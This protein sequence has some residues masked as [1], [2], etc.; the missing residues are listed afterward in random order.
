MRA[1]VTLAFAALILGCSKP[2]PYEPHDYL[3]IHIAYRVPD[4]VLLTDVTMMHEPLLNIRNNSFDISDSECM[5]KLKLFSDTEMQ[6]VIAAWNMSDQSKKPAIGI[7][8]QCARTNGHDK[9]C[10]RKR[11]QSAA[12]I[13][14]EELGVQFLKSTQTSCFGGIPFG[15]PRT[16][17][18]Q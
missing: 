10:E 18:K 4:R 6:K 5:E 14:N 11:L 8:L 3:Q 15:Q 1:I 7:T 12:S 16:F 13:D 2:G 9:Q 17:Y